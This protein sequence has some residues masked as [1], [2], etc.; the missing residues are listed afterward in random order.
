MRKSSAAGRSR[1]KRRTVSGDGTDT[2]N[3]GLLDG[4]PEAKQ[5]FAV[6]AGS[7]LTRRS[8]L[9]ISGPF[10]SISILTISKPNCSVMAKCRS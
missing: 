9:S 10:S 3:Y 5:F 1:A 7:E 2:R 6:T 4:I 8:T